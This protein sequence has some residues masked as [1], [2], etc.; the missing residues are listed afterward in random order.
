MYLLVGLDYHFYRKE[1][2]VTQ[3]NR[4]I[5]RF[6]IFLNES[7]VPSSLH[8][9]AGNTCTRILY[10]RTCTY[11]IARIWQF[12]SWTFNSQFKICQYFIP[13]TYT[14]CMHVRSYWISKQTAK[15]NN[16]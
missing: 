9:T 1:V 12:D 6:P 7:T 2:Y 10:I 8:T 11:C 4:R 14:M 15:P 5:T 3:S 16:H 13:S